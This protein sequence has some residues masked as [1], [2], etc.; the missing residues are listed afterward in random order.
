MKTFSTIDEIR[1]NNFHLISIYFSLFILSLLLLKEEFLSFKQYI[2]MNRKISYCKIYKSFPHFALHK[3]FLRQNLAPT[4]LSP[5]IS[6]ELYQ[7]LFLVIIIIYFVKKILAFHKI[8]LWYPKFEE[9]NIF[10]FQF[11]QLNWEVFF[12][13]SQNQYKVK[14]FHLVLRCYSAFNYIQKR[15]SFEWL[16]DLKTKTYRI[17]FKNKRKSVK[18]EYVS[19]FLH[20]CLIIN[21]WSLNLNFYHFSYVLMLIISCHGN[22]LKKTPTIP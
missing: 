9:R 13:T 18:N 12:S 4:K 14:I 10:I 21:S 20:S 5:F 19:I 8:L 15:F 22:L 16:Y 1:K 2:C 11:S 17:C 3:N 6:S 7:L